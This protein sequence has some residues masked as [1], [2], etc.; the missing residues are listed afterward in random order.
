MKTKTVKREVSKVTATLLRDTFFT[1]LMNKAEYSY[2]REKSRPIYT[3]KSQSQKSQLVLSC[4]CPNLYHNFIIIKMSQITEL[5]VCVSVFMKKFIL[6]CYHFD[7]NASTN[8]QS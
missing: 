5:F 7:I 1:W 8:S 3:K 4:K 2:C 6:N